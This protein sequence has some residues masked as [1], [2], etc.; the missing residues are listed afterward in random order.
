MLLRHS[1]LRLFLV[2]NFLRPVS[3]PRLF[4]STLLAPKVVETPTTTTTFST[5]T[6]STMAHFLSSDPWNQLHDGMQLYHNHF[7]HTFNSIYVRSE[8]I[9]S[10][11][12]DEDELDD[13][14]AY[15]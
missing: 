8:N 1:P 6:A 13:L 3:N 4:P 5:T 11:A 15:A 14:L 7:R 12:E 10:D 2:S 9:S